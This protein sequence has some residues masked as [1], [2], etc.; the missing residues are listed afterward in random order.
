[1]YPINAPFLGVNSDTIH[2]SK[3]EVKTGAYC[4]HVNAVIISEKNISPNNPT[5]PK[6]ILI[7]QI[8]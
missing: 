8:N 5:Y 7:A 2:R 3:I 6:N 4:P 1:M